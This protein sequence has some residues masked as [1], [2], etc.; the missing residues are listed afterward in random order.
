MM[1]L[2]A[3][4]SLDIDTWYIHRCVQLDTLYSRFQCTARLTAS[5]TVWNLEDIN[6]KV[7]S[8]VIELR[9]ENSSPE[10]KGYPSPGAGPSCPVHDRNS[11]YQESV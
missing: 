2:F 9:K 7:A 5:G 3:L 4:Y 11:L 1:L 10:E 6:S 8:D